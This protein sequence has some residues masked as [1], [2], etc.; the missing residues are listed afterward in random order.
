MVKNGKGMKKVLKK[1]EKGI[2][3]RLYGEHF[4]FTKKEHCYEILFI[5]IK[6]SHIGMTFLFIAEASA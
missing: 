6:E 1:N 4:N 2:V 3:Q 5:M